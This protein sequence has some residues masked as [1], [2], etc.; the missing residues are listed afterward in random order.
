MSYE[1]PGVLMGKVRQRGEGYGSRWPRQKRTEPGFK[2]YQFFIPEEAPRNSSWFRGS[3]LIN[4]EQNWKGELRC[5][6]TSCSVLALSLHLGREKRSYQSSPD[7]EKP[8]SSHHPA[9]PLQHCASSNQLPTYGLYDSWVFASAQNTWVTWKAL[10]PRGKKKKTQ[11]L[12]EVASW[13]LNF[14]F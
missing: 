3:C 6:P 1:S 10:P 4:I 11:E 2:P 7:V 13:F 9:E 12:W 5:N 14:P 8:W